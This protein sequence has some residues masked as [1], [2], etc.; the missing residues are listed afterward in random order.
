MKRPF[1]K[2]GFWVMMWALG[3]LLFVYFSFIMGIL[4]ILISVFLISIA[5]LMIFMNTGPT[6]AKLLLLSFQY[7]MLFFLYYLILFGLGKL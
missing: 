3:L 2:V 4:G 6:F 5:S 7:P 1:M